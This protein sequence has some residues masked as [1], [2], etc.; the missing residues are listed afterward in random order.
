LDTLGFVNIIRKSTGMPE[1]SRCPA[2]HLDAALVI[3]KMHGR[4]G[5]PVK[6]R[7]I[8]KRLVP[9]VLYLNS[10]MIQM[11]LMTLKAKLNA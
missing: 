5:L 2:V 6:L 3:E 4:S 9:V 7:F 10:I 1:K 8:G 11:M